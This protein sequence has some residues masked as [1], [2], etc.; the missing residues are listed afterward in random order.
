MLISETLKPKPPRPSSAKVTPN[1]PKAIPAAPQGRMSNA[2]SYRGR[3][4]YL[5]AASRTNGKSTGAAAANPS[6]AGEGVNQES[7]SSG[8]NKSNGSESA[9]VKSSQNANSSV[10]AKPPSGSANPAG[11]SRIPVTS[12]TKATLRVPEPTTNNQTPHAQ[13]TAKARVG[14]PIFDNNGVRLDR[15]PTDEEIN[16]LWEKVRTC[17]SRNS[18]VSSSQS[19]Q[20]TERT[21]SASRQKVPISQKFIDG[22]SLAPQCRATARV[23]S[24]YVPP[25]VAKKLSMN[26]LNNYTRRIGNIQHHQSHVVPT[27]AGGQPT[28]SNAS[29]IANGYHSHAANMNDRSPYQPGN[30]GNYYDNNNCKY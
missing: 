7:T 8:P 27:S 11:S 22:S 28:A 30:N 18:T 26:N 14:E 12:N 9:N 3:G 19:E 5:A 17:L 13:A 6:S 15:T 4:R 24:N 16:W 10:A 1:P 21:N 29:Y 2:G 20:I 23:T 25:N